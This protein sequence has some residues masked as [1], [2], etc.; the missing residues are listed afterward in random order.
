MS[1]DVDNYLFRSDKLL[2]D[3]SAPCHRQL[4]SIQ[5]PVTVRKGETVYIQDEKPQGVYYLQQGKVKIE[6]TNKGGDVRIV[7]IYT[8][9]EFFG[10][11]TLMSN[12]LHPV[13]ATALEDCTLL[14]YKGDDFKKIVNAS[15]TL[16][17]NMIEILGFEFNL[18]VNLIT[19]LSHKSAKERIAFVLLLLSEKYKRSKRLKPEITLTKQDIGRYSETTEETVV[20]VLKFF[21]EQK[22]VKTEGRVV[23]VINKHMLQVIAEGF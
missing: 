9:N 18:W 11:R 3:I 23:T 8:D 2:R 20:R 19:A 12:E 13:T 22:F 7:Y 6:Q 10:F 14:F 1:F 15:P 4:E 5:Q 17:L 16:S 21:E